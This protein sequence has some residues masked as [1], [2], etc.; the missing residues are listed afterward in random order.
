MA[1]KSAKANQAPRV[2]ALKHAIPDAVMRPAAG[3]QPNYR[4]DDPAQRYAY[5]SS[6]APSMQWDD[7]PAR[8]RAEA[9]I[10]VILEAGTLEAAK[11]AAGKLKA[12]GH[13]FLEW[14]GKRERQAFDVETLPLFLHER[15]STQAI[16]QAL[17]GHLR[18]GKQQ[19]M[20]DLYG[21]PG[22]SIADQH[23]KA[24]QHREPWA[25]RLILGDNLQVMNSLLHKERLGGSV[26][27]IY[28][29]P[30]YGVK[31]GSNFQP[32]VR[33]R[34]VSHGDDDDLTREPEMVQAY[35]D[36]WELGLHS[37]LTYL[38]DRLVVARELLHPSGSIFIQISDDNLHHV[39]ELMDEVFGVDQFCSIINFRKTSGASS[40]HAK[41]NVVGT[42]C[43]YLLWYARDAAQVRYRQLFT[44][45]AWEPDSPYH[46]V[47]HEGKRRRMTAAEAS[48]AEPLPEGGRAFRLGELSSMGI[49]P[50]CIFP[51]EI[52]GKKYLPPNGRHWATNPEGMKKLQAAGRV[53][54]SGN[55]PSYVRYQDD[56]GFAPVSNWWEDTGLGGFVEPRI[57]ACQTN[58][59]VVA[60]CLLM[61]TDP[62]DLILD[63]TCGGAT[64][65]YAAEKWGRRWITIDVS[66][67]PLALARQRLLTAAFPWYEL[68]DEAK[69]PAG[70]FVF[71][72]REGRAG[73]IKGGIAVRVTLGSIANAEPP[74]QVVLVDRPEEV[75]GITRVSGPFTFEAMIA[76]AA[77]PDGTPAVNPE[78]VRGRPY[79][80][81]MLAVIRRSPRVALP[82][83]KF[84]EFAGA[85]RAAN[86]LTIHAEASLV[87]GE[88]FPVAVLFGPEHG[89][90]SE[91][92]V[93]DAAF[94]ARAGN[95]FKYLAVVGF[96]IE[97]KAR[98]LIEAS[99]ALF[100]IP[101][102]YI[103][104]TP[105]VTM[106]DLLKNMRSSQVLSVCGLPDIEL[107]RVPA[108]EG[109]PARYAV[110]LL[111]LDVFN[112]ITAQTAH[113]RGDD[114][115]AWFLDTD[116]NG[117]VF[118]TSQAF[119]PRTAAWDNLKRSLRGSFEDSVWEH[120]AGTVSAPFEAGDNRVIAVKVI[121]DR[122]NELLAVR[123][124]DDALALSGPP[125][126]M[127]SA[128]RVTRPAKRGKKR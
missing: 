26:Q 63:P 69:G 57:Y 37:F 49:I 12:M 16:I 41:T 55:T 127:P 43:D 14:A 53:M 101:A 114:V 110:E 23:L 21:D 36:T 91:K 18:E 87:N 51:I 59:K 61:T 13:P 107:R 108:E 30:P 77:G 32:F 95:Y 9:L 1:R 121:D 78:D 58:S 5:D 47:E 89:A 35:R 25:N 76:P 66:R 109:H 19:E 52:D 123:K 50:S 118:M 104:A 34:D 62:G 38:R 128:P 112:P 46:W 45:R 17:R 98:Q 72:R 81:R 126:V 71:R 122:G 56:F 29:D 31:F 116:Y 83:N 27:M 86:T 22:L 106:G 82:G 100:K 85:R 15:L 28:M 93:Y 125:P 90:I 65:A 67:V 113:R 105:D 124:L 92:A 102:V 94:E 84:I 117:L 74:E 54:L 103:A 111:G 3:T 6:L 42:V 11:A 8:E 88:A 39:R 2:D 33:K 115:P 79:L 7:N 44:E 96:A 60:R 4:T 68:K 119:F 20:F 40:P 73:A 120:L 48:G 24:Y 75:K 70:G 97:A 99:A 80:D 10:R 64:S